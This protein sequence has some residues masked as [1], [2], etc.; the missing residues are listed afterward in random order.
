MALGQDGQPAFIAFIQVGFCQPGTQIRQGAQ[1]QQ[2]KQLGLSVS[3]DATDGQLDELWE[4]FGLAGDY[5]RD[6]WRRVNGRTPDDDGVQVDRFNRFVAHLLDDGRVADAIAAHQR[7]RGE[8]S[9]APLQRDWVFKR[10]AGSLGRHFPEQI[11]TR[12][13]LTRVFSFFTGKGKR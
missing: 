7:R 10:V 12:G 9:D 3:A 2:F 1:T 11:Q 5:A 4:R 13:S 6:V 8:S